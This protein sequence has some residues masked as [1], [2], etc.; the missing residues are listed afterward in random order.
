MNKNDS[1]FI[2]IHLLFIVYHPRSKYKY[3]FSIKM[4]QVDIAQIDY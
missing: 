2:F 1:D 3:S 4:S